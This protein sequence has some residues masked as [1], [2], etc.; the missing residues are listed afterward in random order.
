MGHNLRRIPREDTTGES[1]RTLRSPVRLPAVE[2][3][4]VRRQRAADGGVDHVDAHR[5]VLLCAGPWAKAGY[6]SHR[7]ASFPGLL[8]TV[9]RLL[10]LPLEVAPEGPI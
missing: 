2:R 5:T 4:S 3:A 8:K 1:P 10:R 7:N 9:F 6:V